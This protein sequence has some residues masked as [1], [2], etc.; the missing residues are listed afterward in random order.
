LRRVLLKLI[1]SPAGW[2]FDRFMVRWTG[3]SP[4]SAVFAFQNGIKNE[5]RTLVLE[6]KGRKSGKKRSVALAYF[7]IDG[8]LL[9]VGSA[10][11]SPVDPQ[12]VTNLRASPEATIYIARKARRVTTRIAAG[13]ER[14]GLWEKL[15]AQVP[16]YAQ[17]QTQVTRDIPLV[18]LE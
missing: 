13:E 18:I 8:H 9:V 14:R 4:L 6:A 5:S 17:Y 10:G 2:A 15:A 11:G 7:E 1:M 16:T 12:W 3:S